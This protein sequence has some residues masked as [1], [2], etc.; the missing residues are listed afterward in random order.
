M[1]SVPSLVRKEVRTILRHCLHGA[2]CTD[3]LLRQHRRPNRVDV[4]SERVQP[5][6]T[7]TLTMTV[8]TEI[9]SVVAR[10]A[11]LVRGAALINLATAT[12]R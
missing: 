5:P 11:V 9:A 2:G 1:N 8:G 6:K 7:L 12:S 3:G 10:T 4:H